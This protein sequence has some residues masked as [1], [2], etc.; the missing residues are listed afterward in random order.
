MC[1]APELAL[2]AAMTTDAAVSSTAMEGGGYYNR[3]SNLQEAGISLIL[4]LFEAAAETVPID[5]APHAPLVI[6]DYGSSQGR[7]SMGPMA[8]AIDRLRARAGVGRPIEVVHTDLPSNDFA[9]L[10]AAL[11]DDGSSYLTG[12]PGVFPS[13]VGRSYFEPIL[14]PGR[15]HLGWN[16]WTLHW[17]SR[18]PVEVSDHA[19]AVLGASA[20]DRLAARRQ[21]AQDWTDFLA[22]RAF[23][24]APGAK[25]VSL[26][27]GATPET[28]GWDWV[29]GEL[30]EA[31]RDMAGEGLLTEAEL[32]R[33][34]LPVV[35][36]TK[37]D[38][39]AP[40]A[41][42]LFHGLS[43]DY[44]DVLPAPD[45]FWEE[46]QAS[47]DAGQLGARW[48]GMLRAVCGPIAMAAF[49]SRPNRDAL[50]DELFDRVEASLAASPQPHQHFVAIA[51]IRKN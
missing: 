6:A 26:A 18:N 28:H 29:I 14:P 3:N 48:K 31:A 11:H 45:P 42:G 25:L 49:A 2:G 9:S 47:G 34:T 41:A 12:R 36:R 43:L 38:L 46:F 4:P 50:V 16:T 27:M 51:V 30:W 40:F 7:N 8:L 22:A 39:E 13:A 17:L 37:A 23:E 24:M 19:M 15:V 5:G 21:S 32:K 20:A 44:A 1:S 35:G 33:F 10:F